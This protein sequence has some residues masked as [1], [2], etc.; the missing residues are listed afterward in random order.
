MSAW[1]CHRK[2]QH[3]FTYLAAKFC[4]L[5]LLC[6][7]SQTIMDNTVR[8]S[9]KQ[10]NIMERGWNLNT[11][12]YNADQALATRIFFYWIKSLPIRWSTHTNHE[13][14]FYYLQIDCYFFRK[15]QKQETQMIFC[16]IKSSDQS[17][18]LRSLSLIDKC[19][20]FNAFLAI[21]LSS[22]FTPYDAAF[23]LG[24][25]GFIQCQPCSS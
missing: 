9:N 23:L 20:C 16:P 1:R 10:G 6:I 24:G 25:G 18:P 15:Q 5:T 19:A 22:R 14:W 21:F 4:E 2:T 17:V 3:I 8:I 13:A 11:I 12:C 7:T